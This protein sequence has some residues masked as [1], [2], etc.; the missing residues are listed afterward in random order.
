[1]QLNSVWCVPSLKLEKLFRIHFVDS[2]TPDQH[3]P[4]CMKHNNKIG[5]WFVWNFTI[6]TSSCLILP[7]SQ[8]FMVLIFKAGTRLK[9]GGTRGTLARWS[10]NYRK[11]KNKNTT[12]CYITFFWLPVSMNFKHQQVK[13]HH[14]SGLHYKKQNL[15]SQLCYLSC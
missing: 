8:L 12:S 2:T 6:Y 14:W 3:S 4:N 10:K 1:M 15:G 13:R 11:W 5:I 7:H 9:T